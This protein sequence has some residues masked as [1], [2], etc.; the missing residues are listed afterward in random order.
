[1]AARQSTYKSL[2]SIA[3]AILL[4]LGLVI[5]FANLDGVADSVSNFAG[6]SA[7]E[8]LGVLPALGIA[9]LHAAQS[10]AFDHAGFSSSLLQILVSF[11]P[12]VLIFASAIVLRR[13]LGRRS[14]AFGDREGPSTAGDQ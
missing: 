4:A 14:T 7:H 5:L 8:A 11:W 6:S 1:M 3:G 12:L 9:A 13:A 2:N 10:Y